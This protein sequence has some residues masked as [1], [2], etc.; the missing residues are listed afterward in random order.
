MCKFIQ[1]PTS[2]VENLQL[3]RNGFESGLSLP[4]CIG[5][6]DSTLIPIKAPREQE[7]ANVNRK[8]Y[9]FIVLQGVCNH[10]RKFTDVFCGCAGSTHDATAMRSSPLYAEVCKN[11]QK[12]LQDETYLIGDQAYPLQ[13]WL[14]KKYQDTGKRSDQQARFNTH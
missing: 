4:W 8:S 10:K 3:V 2:S 9:H 11:E 1:W 6:I 12:Y 7:N 5:C 13:S 14:M